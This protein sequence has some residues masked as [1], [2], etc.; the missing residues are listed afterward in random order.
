MALSPLPHRPNGPHAGALVSFRLQGHPVSG[1]VIASIEPYT[2]VRSAFNKNRAHISERIAAC[3]AD[4]LGGLGIIT[5][6]NPIFIGEECIAGHTRYLVLDVGSI[7]A[8]SWQEDPSEPTK[9]ELNAYVYA[10]STLALE[11]TPAGEYAP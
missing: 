2:S 11:N 7:A 5:D 6:I 3:G 4:R 1:E 9:G 10:L 8:E